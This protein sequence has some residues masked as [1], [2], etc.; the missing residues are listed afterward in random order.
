MIRA[1]LVADKADFVRIPAN[2]SCLV[3]MSDTHLDEA[4]FFNRKRP[5][6]FCRTNSPAKIA[7]FLTI[8]NPGNEPR[9]IKAGETCF[10]EC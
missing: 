5:D 9:R 7:E 3:D 8:P 1:L 10:Q 2:A 4:L 6:R